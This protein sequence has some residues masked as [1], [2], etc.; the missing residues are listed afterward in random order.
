MSRKSQIEAKNHAFRE[1]KTSNKL[2][3]ML[4]CPYHEAIIDEV[5][6]ESALRAALAVPDLEV[7]SVSF[8]V[9]SIL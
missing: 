7:T 3:V 9:S 1:G 5:R 4:D 6:I 8:E 2:V